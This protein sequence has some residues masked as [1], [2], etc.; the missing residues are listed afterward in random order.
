MCGIVGYYGKN[1]KVLD[2]LI[3]GLKRLEYR[4]YD[5]AG[6]AAITE[7]NDIFCV[8]E[9]GRVV[10]LEE[11]I[12]SKKRPDL[13]GI[14]IAHTRWATHGVPSQENSHPH[15][16]NNQKI[17]LIHN[18]IIENYQELKDELIADGIDFYSQTDTEV[19]AN[20]IQKYYENDLREA[21]LKALSRV[22]GAYALL[23]ICKDEPDRMIAAKKG[24]PL[25]MGVGN[26]EFLFGSDVSPIIHK[27]KDVIYLEDGELVDLK[28]GKYEIL[29]LKNQN[30]AKTIQKV[31]W[32]EEAASKEGYDHFLLKEITEQPKVI[33]DSIR[34]RLILDEG[35]IKFGGLIDVMDRLK[36]IKKVVILGIGTSFYAAK[37]GELYFEAIGGIPAKAEMSPEFRYNDSA[38][39]KYTWVIAISQSGET[40]D[41]IAAI[42]EAKRKGALV[43]GIVNTVG[44]TISRITDAGV[45]NHIGPEISVASTKAFSSQVLLLLMHA[46]LLGRSKRLGYTDGIELVKAIQELPKM[47]AEVLDQSDKIILLAKKYY[48]Y[49]NLVYVGRKYNYPI[50]LEGALKLKEIS[51]IH[52]EGLSGGEFKHGFIALIDENMP[53]IAIATKDSIYEKMVSNIQE[54]RARSGKIITI[55]SQ[56]DS[57]IEKFSEDTIFVPNSTR[58][59]VQPLINNIVLQLFAYYCSTLKGLDVDKPRNLAKSVTV[60]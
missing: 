23:I 38:I 8:K 44:S 58:E 40:A 24:S 34:G 46:I 45:Y 21:V 18:G 27:T 36:K 43:T 60:E 16:S 52:A 3:S 31:E 56:G 49:D 28:D 41:T 53:T 51:Y 13:K 14:G 55:A 47:I 57:N 2:T 30:I 11:S 50:A 1:K 42:E 33:E 10:K 5:S 20:L 48:K 35:G 9:A 39:D 6:I 32:D 19:V 12:N 29:N 17:F 22:V 25:V 26:D 37:L 7:N 15:N 59:E 4:G 54:I